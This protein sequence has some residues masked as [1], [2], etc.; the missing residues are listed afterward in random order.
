MAIDP[1]DRET[2]Q[3]KRLLPFHDVEYADGQV[4][5]GKDKEDHHQHAGC[6]PAGP[7][8]FDLSRHCAGPD[9]G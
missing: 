8:L 5:E 2:E 9:P 4:A 7:D 1:E 3:P 6:L